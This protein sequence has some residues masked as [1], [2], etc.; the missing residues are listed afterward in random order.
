MFQHI[1]YPIKNNDYTDCVIL[2]TLD[3]S[4]YLMPVHARD[5]IT[6][7]SLATDAIYALQNGK[8]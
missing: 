8:L 7:I 5:V 2:Y 6:E 1:E 3:E 4:Y